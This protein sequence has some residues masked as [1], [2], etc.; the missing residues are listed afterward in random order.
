M[1]K[2][3]I[4]ISYSNYQANQQKIS[5]SIKS[6]K[7]NV[8]YS[9]S[10]LWSS[11]FNERKETTS[12]FNTMLKLLDR[13]NN[14]TSGI[15]SRVTGNREQLFVKY[16]E[17]FISHEDID[18]YPLSLLGNPTLI[19]FNG[20]STNISYLVNLRLFKDLKNAL[21][22][23]NRTKKG[24][25]ILEIG[26]GYGGL[27]SILLKSDMPVS[28]TIID[29]PENLVLSNFYLTEQFPEYQ[30][31]VLGWETP[32]SDIGKNTL[33][34]LTPGNIDALEHVK[35]DL[36]INTDSLGEMPK[37]TSQAYIAWIAKHLNEDG[38]F[39][40]KNGHRRSEDSTK[41]PSEFGYDQFE[42]SFLSGFN[43]PGALWDDHSHLALLTNRKPN[44]PAFDNVKFDCICQ[45]LAL[46][47]VNESKRLCEGFVS[48]NFTKEENRF[49]DDIDQYFTAA[50]KL[51]ADKI[52]SY[53]SLHLQNL[54][55]YLKGLAF[56]TAHEKDKAR[57]L[58][59]SFLPSA[60]SNVSEA[61]TLFV[62][63]Q[64]KDKNVLNSDFNLGSK[65]DFLAEEIREYTRFNF[66][67]GKLV[68]LM[69]NDIVKKKINYPSLYHPS[70]VMKL[71]NLYLNMKDNKG[72][73]VKRY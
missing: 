23:I 47:L 71:K 57:H 55:L 70:M 52:G 35:F 64:L 46:G 32:I 54:S 61:T 53:E 59:E 58:L 45:L 21:K 41:V 30:A 5:E 40:S 38:L 51:K 12:S 42:L 48:N 27:A 37:S 29:L 50:N 43:G 69:R 19:D 3:N 11:L 13:S 6:Q 15:A 31:H 60:S 7:N 10:A 44:T 62:L 4:S 2:P 8:F 39:F 72:F 67:K 9:Y 18:E 66:V 17:N 20:K 68:F 24:I 22:T 14:I 25:N 26:A 16:Y 1:C 56:F 63:A 65:T 36:V 28:Y 73:S 33:N 49:L 34:F